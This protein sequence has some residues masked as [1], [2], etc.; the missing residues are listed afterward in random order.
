MA[1]LLSVARV[2]VHPGH[3][4]EYLRVIHQLAAL[5]AGR[6]QNLWVFQS[7]SDPRQYLEFS[8]SRTEMSHRSRASRTDLELKLERRLQQIAE[9]APGAS[10]L[11]EELPAPEPTDVEDS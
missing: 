2:T 10:D 9:Y 8:E 7:G 6:G 11:W 1:R 4:E 3:Q 5:G